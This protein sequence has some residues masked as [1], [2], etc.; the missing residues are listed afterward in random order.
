MKTKLNRK[1]L[2][3]TVLSVVAIV[4]FILLAIGSDLGIVP[5]APVRTEYLKENKIYN[6]H[7]DHKLV[8][9][10]VEGKRDEWGRWHGKTL[11]KSG[12]K[13]SGSSEIVYVIEEVE[14][15][16]GLRNFISRT[17]YPDGPLKEVV[18]H[19]GEVVKDF[20]KGTSSVNA[21]PS[22]FEVLTEKYP[23]FHASLNGFGF[24]DDYIETF[25]DTLQLLLDGYE[26]DFNE[27]DDYYEMVLDELSLTYHDSI[28]ALNSNLSILQGLE[29]LKNAEFRLS[30]VDRY[31]SDG[32]STYDVLKAR[33]PNY[34]LSLTE[35]GISDAD[36][37]TFCH[38]FD[39]TLALFEPLNPE[40]P[41][42]TDSI[43]SYMYWALLSFVDTAEFE[44]DDEEEQEEF[45]VK[46]ENLVNKRGYYRAL[47]R[48]AC[49]ILKPSSLKSTPAEVGEVV[50][51]LMFMEHYV[52]GDMIKRVVRKAWCMDE[53]I[54]NV[55][56]TA[57]D[58]S[59]HVSATG[60]MLQGYVID[61]GGDAVTDRGIVWADY[62]NPILDDN[63]ETS[64]SGTGSFT[65]TITGLTEG[66]T[67]YARTYATNS[68]GTTYGNCI[69]FVAAEPSGIAESET[70]SEKFSIY[71]NP[72]SGLTTFSFWLDLPELVKVT[73]TDM[74]GSQVLSKDLGRLPQG[75]NQIKLDLSGLQQG[76]YVC[77]LSYGSAEVTRRLVVAR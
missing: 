38:D 4:F 43:D 56:S 75:N 27:F 6:F 66:T 2:W 22:A 69:E 70:L 31:R 72:A 50:A 36:F 71:P 42:F 74:K 57:T 65:V 60:V 77:R 3:Q 5:D 13:K 18:Y 53:G 61:D 49:S 28:I 34:I 21:D 26:F 46:T 8:S 35:E 14:M 7:L 11:I 59:A 39:D 15:E 76:M 9:R 54:I 19:H 58:F 52:K 41:F 24:G 68:A 40:D 55:P 20:K 45:S 17:Y 48:K 29:E 63:V 16:E 67:Y 23:W 44:D 73:I 62:Y 12:Y 25:M 37:E 10:E 1:A 47:Y 64:G 33:Y 30:V 51:Y 32:S